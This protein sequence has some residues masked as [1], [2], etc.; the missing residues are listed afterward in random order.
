MMG[1]FKRVAFLCQ[2]TANLKDSMLQTLNAT[3]KEL[4]LELR[5]KKLHQCTLF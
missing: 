4:A 1:F 5:E 3:T 2:P